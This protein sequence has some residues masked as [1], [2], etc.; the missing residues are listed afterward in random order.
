MME[1]E[2][3][4]DGESD[5]QDSSVRQMM[6]DIIVVEPIPL[7]RSL[8][9]ASRSSVS[10]STLT[11]APD[12]LDPPTRRTAVYNDSISPEA[13]FWIEINPPNPKN[14]SRE[15]YEINEEEFNVLDIL[16]DSGDDDSKVYK[17][18][19]EDYHTAT[20]SHLPVKSDIRYR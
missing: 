18:Q 20:V 12:I 17:V 13:K 9:R 19:F 10:S 11:P 1:S 2:S 16:D 6:E 4:M 7:R 5:I 14:L 3:I 15:L 8:R